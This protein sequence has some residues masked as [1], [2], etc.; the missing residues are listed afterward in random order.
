[1]KI[2]DSSSEITSWFFEIIQF[3]LERK[4][5]VTVW[6]GWGTSFDAWYNEILQLSDE[7]WELLHKIQWCV[8]DERVNCDISERNDAH[9]WNI[10][11]QP[12]FQKYWISE[13]NFVRPIMESDWAEYSERVGD[14]DIA[15]F[16]MGPD[17]HTASLFPHHP[18]LS[19]E[20]LWF[21]KIENAPKNP[22]ERISLSPKSIQ[23]LEH[24]CLFAV[25][26]WKK[27]AFTNFLNETV[28]VD[29]CPVKLL[30]PEV[31]YLSI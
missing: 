16:G 14:I 3:S 5:S 21:I 25:W 20:E 28:S 1:M 13:E 8:T 7:R 29:D 9:I 23:S 17:G 2:T 12:L 22:P 15:F 11:L 31:V 27:E 18:A 26:A 10:F 6:L 4:K 19:S 24:V 30:K